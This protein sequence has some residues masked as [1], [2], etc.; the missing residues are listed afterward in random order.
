MVKNFPASAGNMGSIPGTGK[1]P[2]EEDGNS[3]HYSSLGKPMDRGD[4]QAI[5]HGVTKESDRT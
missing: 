4:C 2:G 5:I 1:S 3:L